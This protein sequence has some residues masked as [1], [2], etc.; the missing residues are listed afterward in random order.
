MALINILGTLNTS[1]AIYSGKY[2]CLLTICQPFSQIPDTYQS[3]EKFLPLQNA[4]FL[5]KDAQ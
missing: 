1:S 5:G 2:S 3:Q 4:Y